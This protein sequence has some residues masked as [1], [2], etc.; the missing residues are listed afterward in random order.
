MTVSRP[1]SSLDCYSILGLSFSKDH[2][3]LTRSD[4]KTAY[5]RTLLLHHPDKVI[6]TSPPTKTAAE[7]KLSIDTITAAYKTLSTPGLRREHDR[8]LLL[9][10]SHHLQRNE[11]FRTGVEEVD[12]DDLSYDEPRGVWTRGCRCGQEKGFV[13]TAKMLEEADAE[14]LGEVRVGCLGCSLW[15]NVGFGVED[16]ERDGQ[17][18]E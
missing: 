3:S 7:D 17:R 2:L 6:S 4:I 14:G 18:G 16:G 13:V 1:Q 10:Q 11:D 12:L 5:H 9:R 15:L 8:E